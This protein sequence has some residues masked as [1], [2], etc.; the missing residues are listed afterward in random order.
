[1]RMEIRSLG[2]LFASKGAYTLFPLEWLCTITA[3]TTHHPYT[4]NKQTNKKEER[5]E[6]GKKEKF[7]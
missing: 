7:S 3:I 6:K 2:T 5:K 4:S 1:M